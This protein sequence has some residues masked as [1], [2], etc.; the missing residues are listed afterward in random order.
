MKYV[1]AT[2]QRRLREWMAD[3]V[4]AR[5]DLPGR[6]QRHIEQCPR[7]QRRVGR[8]ARVGL[9][10]QLIRSQPHSM[11]LLLQANR[12]TMA[13]LQRNVRELPAALRLQTQLPRASLWMR[14][15][16]VT[17]STLSAAAC[18]LVLLAARTSILSSIDKA[19]QG[20]AQTAKHLHGYIDDFYTSSGS[21]HSPTA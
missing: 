14:V 2:I 12:R 11:S 3:L 7:C 18:L 20:S 17:Q 16:N 10:M 6:L 19:E 5:L 9:A 15:T 21:D 4:A 13:F 8:Y 1:H